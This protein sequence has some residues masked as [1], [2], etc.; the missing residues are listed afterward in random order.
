MKNLKIALKLTIGFGTI[1]IALIVC[2]TFA[3]FG[4]RSA[5]EELNTFYK[6]PF[7]NVALSLQVGME[8]E[9]AAKYMLR[10][11]LEQ[12]ATEKAKMLTTAS[13]YID[14]TKEHLTLLK[15]NYTGD[16]REITEV[17]QYVTKLETAFHDLELA[18]ESNN[19][20]EIY[21]VYKTEIVDCL[22]AISNKISVVREHAVEV[23]KNAYSDS[24]ASSDI[25]VYIMIGIGGIAIL[26]GFIIAFYLT[27]ILTSAIKQ[28]EEASKKLSQGDFNDSITYQSKDEL[29]Q[30]AESMRGSMATLREVVRDLDY[31]LG[32]LSNGNLDTHT[33]AEDS[34]VGE[35]RPILMAIRKLKKDL[36]RTMG[37]IV[38]ASNQVNAGADQVSAGAQSLAQG[39]TEQAS[40]VEELA[41]TIS[42]VSRQIALTADSAENAKMRNENST[43]KL[44]ECS[45][46][47]SELVE[48]MHT[49]EE[50]SS[51]VS[52]VIKAIDDIAFQTNILA[53]N[54]AVE[55]ARAGSA[56]KGFAV[57]AEEVRTLA[58]KSAE[59]AKNTANLIEEAIQ[60]VGDGTRL[61][62]TTEEAL[63]KV[64]EDSEF[65]L[66]AVIQISEA[67]TQ[68][69]DAAK[70][71][72]TGVTQ[73]SDVVQT[74]SA[75]AEQ[76]AA[77]SE[78]LSGQAQVLLGMVSMFTLERED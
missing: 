61:T 7:T 3:I 25:T 66:E 62:N 48:A 74:N 75:T 19:S 56:G 69:A 38:T 78:E 1:L 28:I 13:E 70:Q 33:K 43:Q 16:A 44:Q 6:Y 27:H 72:N 64:V 63:N 49:I 58:G 18:S 4:L 36:N 77:A 2:V 23:A 34:Y 76:S 57:V 59:A 8:G 12:D 26:F 67:T 14:D 54:A 47:M 24:K 40:A 53:L 52:K 35:L 60:A 55:A 45:K 22:T 51:E 68:Q 73:I 32:E 50:R 21:K 42:E 20:V 30:L 15:A 11:C 31:L 5:S 41:A 10:S 39:S 46:Y 71:I 17:E 9:V 37:G 29:G 65:I